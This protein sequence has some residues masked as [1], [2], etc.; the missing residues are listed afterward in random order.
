[1]DEI[2]ILKAR[3]MLYEH[4]QARAK[5]PNLLARAVKAGHES[6]VLEAICAWGEK[7]KPIAE[8]WQEISVLVQNSVEK[9]SNAG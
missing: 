2:E 8:I 1:M 3:E 4:I 9:S 7:K 5:L 6:Q